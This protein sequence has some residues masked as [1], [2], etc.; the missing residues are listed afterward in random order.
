MCGS[1]YFLTIVDDYSRAVW[2]YLL[3]NKSE[4]ASTLKTFIAMVERQFDKK[5]QD[6]KK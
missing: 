4:T 6:H 5:A 1:R 3:P 2:I